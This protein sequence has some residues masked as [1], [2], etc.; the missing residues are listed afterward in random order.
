MKI[1]VVGANLALGSSIV[2]EAE[3]NKIEVTSIVESPINVVGNGPIKIVDTY[4]DLSKIDFNNYHVVIDT[5]SFPNIKDYKNSP[6]LSLLETL[7][8]STCKYLGI[9]SVTILLTGEHDNTKVGENSDLYLERRDSTT[10]Q[11]CLKLYDEIKK[12]N[13]NNWA[14]LCPPLKFEEKGYSH[15][16]F[17]FTYD[18]LALNLDGSSR[19]CKADFAK[20]MIELLKLGFKIGH[21]ICVAS[22]N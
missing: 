20:A 10:I 13:V 8:G 12:L 9:G 16:N 11:E 17:F 4:S 15:N 5:V 3:K 2:L 21:S 1:A 14:F 18:Y 22:K 6:V 7:K 19:I